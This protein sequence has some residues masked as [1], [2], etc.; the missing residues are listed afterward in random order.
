V[1]QFTLPVGYPQYALEKAGKI[2]LATL[3]ETI[4]IMETDILSADD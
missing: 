3:E 4:A 1:F 2:R